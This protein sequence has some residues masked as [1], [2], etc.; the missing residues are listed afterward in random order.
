MVCNSS[1]DMY[2]QRIRMPDVFK[3]STFFQISGPN[4]YV[5]III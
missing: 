2:A 5:V 4:K 3:L 1:G